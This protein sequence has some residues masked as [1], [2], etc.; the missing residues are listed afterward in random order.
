MFGALTEKL[1]GVFGKLARTRRLT[2]DNISDAVREVRL[3]L[4]EAD[5]NYGVTKT[6]VKRLKEKAVGESVLKAVSPGQQFIKIVHDE[7]VALMGQDEASITIEDNR[8]TVV[9]LCGLQG[10]GKTTHCAKLAHYLRKEGKVKKPLLVACDLQRP[11]AVAQLQTLGAQI[12]V[13]V[14]VQE[15]EQNPVTV[16]RAA[17]AQAKADK[18]DL[19]ILDTAGRLHV[20][21]EL[22]EQLKQVRD[23]VQ[24]DEILFVASATTGQ[25]AVN[26]AKAFNDEVAIDG[27]IL[28]MLDSDARAG[29]AIS[30]REV[31]GKPLKFEGVGEKL[32]DLQ[33]FHPQSMAD[34]IL[35]MGDTINLVRKAQ[36]H[37]DEEQA[38]ELE[39]KIRKATFTYEDYLNQIQAVKKMGSFKKLLGML[40]GMGQLRDLPIDDREFTKVEA[41]IQSMTPDERRERCELVPSRRRRIAKGSGTSLDA[42]NRLLKSFRN[43]KKMFKNLPTNKKQL[44]KMF[45]GNPWH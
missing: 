19:V 14:F 3:A 40:P 34:R 37:F 13:P 38:E 17:L 28:T 23:A 20:D 9:M 8:P 30:I 31:T 11:A 26:T 6:L 4:L 5:V 21:A 39:Q 36:E 2:E 35:G 12:Q 25:D 42:V 43:A 27:S 16:A 18:H 15:G 41:I 1:N 33:A 10:A 44:E 7:L 22:M 24:P 32:G 45:G 29:A